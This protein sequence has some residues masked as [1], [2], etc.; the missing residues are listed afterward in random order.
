MFGVTPFNKSVVRRKGEPETFSDL[1]DDFFGD[2]FFPLRSLRYDTFKV[3]IR[4]EDNAYLIEADMPGVKKEDIHLDYHD[5]LL[6]ISIKHEESKEEET[7]NYVHRER[8][9][10]SMHR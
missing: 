7:K 2:D 1:I 6:N 10:A 5:G 9:H 3:D 4:E 8:K